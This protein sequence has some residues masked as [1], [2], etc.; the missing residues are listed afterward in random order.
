MMILENTAL[1]TWK[2]KEILN[3]FF[4]K[5]LGQ[6]FQAKIEGEI[7]RHEVDFTHS[8]ELFYLLMVF[9][10]ILPLPSNRPDNA[11]QD[12]DELQENAE[13]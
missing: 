8:F 1:D 5:R 9:K 10:I 12:P 2:Y 13:T 4:D 6:H 3:N 11:D 7:N